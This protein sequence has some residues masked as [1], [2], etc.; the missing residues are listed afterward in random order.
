ML[1]QEIEVSLIGQSQ[2]D[3]KQQIWSVHGSIH[4]SYFAGQQM[5]LIQAI[6]N[7]HETE[8]ELHYLALKVGGFA[9]EE[10]AKFNA[11]SFAKSVLFT[12]DDL[13]KVES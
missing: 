2:F 4:K 7:T 1:E 3:D 8:F 10:D 9:S 5:L 6:H 13:I 12:L 11:P